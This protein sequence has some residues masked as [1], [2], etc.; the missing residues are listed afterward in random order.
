MRILEPTTFIM[1]HQFQSCFPNFFFSPRIYTYSF[2]L[3]YRLFCSLLNLSEGT[4]AETHLYSAQKD[5][6]T[7]RKSVPFK[8][9]EVFGILVYFRLPFRWF[10]YGCFSTVSKWL[11]FYIIFR[12]RSVIV[13]WMKHTED[14]TT[15]PLLQSRRS[16]RGIIHDA[17]DDQ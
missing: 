10:S 13:V 15:E 3:T 1:S 5:Y 4:L 11:K 8:I 14:Y 2:L 16:K 12:V 6:P 7:T 9:T 17:L